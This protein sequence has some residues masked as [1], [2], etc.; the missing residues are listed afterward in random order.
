MTTKS[1]VGDAAVAMRRFGWV[2]VAVVCLVARPV[3]AQG[4]REIAGTWQGTLQ[5]GKEQRIVVKIA[6]DGGGWKGVVFNLDSDNAYE[7]RATTQMSL[8]GADLQFAIAAIS[9]S[10]VG[11]LSED[12]ATIAGMWTQGGQAR[13]LNLARVEG[14]AA[15]EIPKAMTSM[16]KDADPDWDVVTV[17]PGNPDGKNSGFHLNGRQ[18][19]MERRTVESMLLFGYGV[20]KKQILNAPGWIESEVWDVKGVPDV[21]GQP[22]LK[23][24]ETLTRKAL[25]ERFGLVTHIEKRD[26]EVYALRVAKGG[27]KMT[28]SAG[29]PNGLPNENDRENGGQITVQMENAAAGELALLLKFM[30]DRPV[31]DQTGLGG[32]YDF[33]L[34]WTSDESKVPA[35]GSAPPTIFTAI[36]EQLGL[37]LEAVK[38]QTDVMVVDKVERPG[39]N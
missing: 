5:G 4:P 16:P 6:R 1:L 29:D 18:V 22:S 19:F 11:K 26:M 15:W 3:V 28:P 31:V 17:R 10:Y 7:G 9:G 32:R 33:L 2:A 38:A 21:P 39:A 24:F 13:P 35:D 23:Q 14:D 36:Q 34:K 25:V 37:K 30:M 8:E 20:H 27:P 12:G